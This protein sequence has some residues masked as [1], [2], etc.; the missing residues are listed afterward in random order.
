MKMKKTKEF[1]GILLSDSNK[2]S[3]KRFIGLI[4]LLMF[5]A[6]GIVGLIVP[7]NKEFW[8]FY[9]S[10]LAVTMWIA[11]KFMTAEKILK[12]GVI[13]Q[14]TKFGK[15]SDAVDGFVGKEHELDANVQSGATGTILQGNIGDENL[16]MD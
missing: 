14:L 1:F 2:Y 6:Y 7:F 11:F 9:V 5:V 3:T 16:P 4:C 13:E 8:I 10:L 15:I 12:Y